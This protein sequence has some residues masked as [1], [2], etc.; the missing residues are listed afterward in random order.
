MVDSEQFGFSTYPTL[1][2]LYV[3]YICPVFSPQ[4][5]RLFISFEHC[6]TL[7]PAQKVFLCVKKCNF[8]ADSTSSTAGCPERSLLF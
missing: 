1:Y 8:Y 3:Q 7:G 2:V 4:E 5:V 6:E